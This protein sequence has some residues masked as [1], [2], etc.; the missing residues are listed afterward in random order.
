MAWFKIKGKKEEPANKESVTEL[1]KIPMK[2]E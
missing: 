1:Y 2:Y